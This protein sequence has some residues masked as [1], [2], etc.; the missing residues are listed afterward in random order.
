[1]NIFDPFTKTKSKF[2][3]GYPAPIGSFGLFLDGSPKAICSTCKNCKVIRPKE[4]ICLKA[5]V[6]GFFVGQIK[7]SSAACE[8]YE[9]GKKKDEEPPQGIREQNLDLFKSK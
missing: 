2:P 5:K 7:K 9:K 8:L 6:N 3:I 4:Y 1:M